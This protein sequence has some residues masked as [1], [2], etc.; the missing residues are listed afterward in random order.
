M[1]P[2]AMGKIVRV[3]EVRRALYMAIPRGLAREL[4][5]FKRSYLEVRR[6]QGQTLT[7]RLIE[8]TTDADLQRAGRPAR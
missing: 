5:I 3:F 7:A 2:M 1:V 8:P 6:G 4:R